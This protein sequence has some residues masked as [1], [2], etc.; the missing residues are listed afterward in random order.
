LGA[1][2]VGLGCHDNHPRLL[3]EC[4]SRVEQ[5]HQSVLYHPDD[6]HGATL[7]KQLLQRARLL[8]RGYVR[9]G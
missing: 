6:R 9:M 4:H 3:R 7:G 1:S 5:T 2:S 8:A